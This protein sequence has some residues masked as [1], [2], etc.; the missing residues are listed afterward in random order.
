[1]RKVPTSVQARGASYWR[2]GRV[3]LY[4]QESSHLK[5]RVRGSREQP[6]EITVTW[7]DLD[8]E[9][10]LS[11][12]CDCPYAVRSGAVCKHIWAVLLEMAAVGWGHVIEGYAGRSPR[13]KV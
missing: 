2:Q 10:V 1:M 3:E 8:G 9:L 4:E 13:L 5:A 6:Y 7:Q 12:R 11:G